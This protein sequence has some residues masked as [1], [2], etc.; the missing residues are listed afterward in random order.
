MPEATSKNT[1]LLENQL[2]H[3][4]I[5]S[6]IA[7]CAYSNTFHVP[8]LF[9]DEGSIQLN[10]YVHGLRNFFGGGY[11]FL[12]NRVVGY[13]TFALNYQLGELNVVGYH[14]VNILIHIG[15]SLLVYSLMLVTSLTPAF[16]NSFSQRQINIF[17]LTVALLF[18]SHPIQTQAVTY[19]VQRIASLATLLYL[20]ALVC[21]IKW[22]ISR[23]ESTSLLK[24]CA[25]S[26]YILSLII[27]VLA[28]KTKEISFTLPLI[29]LLYECS[30]FGRPR[31]KLLIQMTPLFLTLAIIPYTVFVSVNPT[32]TLGGSILSDVNAPA[33]SIVR[34]TRWE[35]FLTQFNVILTYLRLMFLP[36]HQNLDYDYPISHSL[37]EP[38]VM[39]SALII[40]V[41]LALAVYLFMLSKPLHQQH[42]NARHHQMYRLA[43]FGI[44][45]FFITLSVES[46]IIVIRDVIFEHRLYLPSFGFFV[47]ITAFAA[48]AIIRF[49]YSV[50]KIHNAVLPLVITIILALSAATYS[51]NSVW[52]NWF[53]IWNDTVTK[54]P[55]KPRPHNILGIGYYYD[56][57]FDEALREFQEAVRLKPDFIE[58]YYNIG[59]IYKARN[60]YLEAIRIYQMSLSLSAFNAEHFAGIY[61]EIGMCYAE[62]GELEHSATAFAAAVKYNPDS[63]E[64]RNNYAFAL[65]TKGNLNDALREYQAALSLDPGNEYALDAI[66]EINMQKAGGG[67]QTTNPLRA[68]DKKQ[69]AY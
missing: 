69:P 58:A 27:T 1:P 68:T 52:G 37:S 55:N 65:S 66:Q 49:Q 12:P 34:I 50:K 4:L 61:N 20:A 23:N 3:I 28:M 53:S 7:L 2:L 18:V 33:Y 10:A 40:A 22:R 46:S 44:L 35:Y 41:I 51:R 17:A 59:L 24:G 19:I 9:D 54:S 48:L 45:W 39:L 62:I 11:N 25:T 57:K 67:K 21:Y 38:R 63:A 31:R 36:I 56:S 60:Q 14:I 16:K 29:I 15:S 6:A 13:F 47:A 32:I 5:I 43:S 8:F 26:W 42:A 30:F 64:F